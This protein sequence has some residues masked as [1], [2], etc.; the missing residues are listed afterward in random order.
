M[1]SLFCIAYLAEEGLEIRNSLNYSLNNFFINSP[2]TTKFSNIIKAFVVIVFVKNE[3]CCIK[4]TLEI[5]YLWIE[6]GGVT[7]IYS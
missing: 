6:G 4:M 2:I 3:V 1:L 5:S 7:K